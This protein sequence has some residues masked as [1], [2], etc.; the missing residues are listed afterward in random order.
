M[1]ENNREI[2]QFNIYLPDIY[3]IDKQIFSSAS[4][5]KMSAK[6]DYLSLKYL[7]IKMLH[8]IF[9]LDLI[10]LQFEFLSEH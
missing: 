4:P 3:H 1:H 10:Q 8:F 7:L 9:K 5:N 6:T 2:Y